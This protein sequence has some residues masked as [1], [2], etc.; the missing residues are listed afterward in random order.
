VNRWEEAQPIYLAYIGL[1]S[2]MGE[3]EQLLVDAIHCLVQHP[4]IELADESPLYE[5]DPV[6]YVEQDA[7]LN[8]VVAVRTTLP[9]DRLYR[10]MAETELLLGRTRDIRWGP[11]T[12]DMDLLLLYRL[13]ATDPEL[14]SNNRLL[15]DTDD[16]TVP[17]PRMRERAFVLIPLLDVISRLQPAE[18][19]SFK[20][21]LDKLEGKAGVRLWKK[22]KSPNV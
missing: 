16:L 3:R 15:I 14:G 21:H 19:V 20:R 11:R 1:G 12:I 18:A 17:H 10:K 7:F 13:G 9:P 4:D 2:N 6:G 5:T 8:Q 22:T